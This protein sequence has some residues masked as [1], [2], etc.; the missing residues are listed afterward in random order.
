MKLFLILIL[1]TYSF[2]ELYS[3]GP[4][5]VLQKLKE[6][7]E[8]FVTGQSIHPN[9]DKDRIK[10][11]ATEGQKPIA[12]VLAC[13]DSRSPVEILF[14]QGVGDLFVIKVA[15]NVADVDEI[16][17]IE[18]GTAHLLTPLLIVLGHTK[19]GAVTAVATNAELHGHLPKLVDN[20]Q[21]AFEKA[22]NDNPDKHDKDLVDATIKANTFQAI[23]DILS[24]SPIVSKLVK[25]EKLKVVGAIYDIETGNVNWIGSHPDELNLINSVKEGHEAADE[26]KTVAENHNTI[27]EKSVTS[28]QNNSFFT[29]TNV[30]F[31]SIF[32]ATFLVMVSLITAM[33]ILL[34]N[35]S[36]KTAL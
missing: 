27:H 20:I 29:S 21:P 18:Y 32:L 8:R 23:S 34:F 1:V 16:A 3:I 14:D 7:N 15:G 25:E 9:I 5:E 26:N 35:R 24:K 36:R 19:C 13:S 33:I 30:L 6:G 22:K 10:N 17:T 12:T 4:E 31:I 28:E 2:S 11:T